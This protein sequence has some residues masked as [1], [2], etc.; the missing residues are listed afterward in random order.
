MKGLL[1]KDSYTILKQMKIFLVLIFVFTCIPNFS[2]LSFA[3]VYAT[4]I[5][6]TAIGYDERSKWDKLASVMPY[7]VKDIV[8]S[9]YILGYLMVVVTAAV[10]CI[11]QAVVGLFIG[12]QLTQEFFIKLAYIICF[13]LAIEAIDLPLL[14]RFGIE[15]G[16]LLIILFTVVTVVGGASLIENLTK[17]AYQYMENGS[18][19]A[20]SAAGM[21]IISAI[22]VFISM[23]LYK[24]KAE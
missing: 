7:S 20:L 24:S 21:L 19:L 11:A 1:I 2:A 12:T 10:A 22:S 5:P 23:K 9:K 16:R 18:I 6:M 4:M 14:I 3:I 17:E 15:K 8:L 13:A